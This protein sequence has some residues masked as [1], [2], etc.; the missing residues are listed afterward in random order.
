MTQ[1]V[2]DAGHGGTTDMGKSTAYGARGV[3]GTFEKDITLDIARRVA[4]ELGSTAS[5]TRGNDTNLPLAQRASMVGYGGVFVSIH[6]DAEQPGSGAPQAWVHTHADPNSQRLAHAI[7][8]SLDS[9]PGSYGGGGSTGCGDLALLQS[10]R[11]AACLVE[12][13]NIANPTT[14]RRLADPVERAAIGAAI[15][16][17]IR[18]YTGSGDGGYAE[19]LRIVTPN[20]DYRTTSLAD[21]VRI[22]ADYF[23]RYAQWTKG[24]D[25]ASLSHFPHSAICQLQLFNS[26]GSRAWGTGFF[27][28]PNKI[29]SCGHNFWDDDP[30]ETVRVLVQPGASPNMSI[31][32]EQEFTVRGRDLVHPNWR[33]GF[34]RNADLAVLNTPGLS[35]PGGHYFRLANQSLASDAKVVVCGYGKQ[36][37]SSFASQPQRMDGATISQADSE[38]V[39]YPI[40]TVGG[41][42]GSPLFHDDMVIGVHTGPRIV[43]ESPL[44]L[45]NHENRAVRIVPDNETWINRM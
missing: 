4:A 5:L 36:D 33:S 16:R 35:A 22:W 6:A 41:H 17:G 18:T 42:S 38:M 10:S 34:A 32:P 37:G 45:S 8:R 39:W 25:N 20:I 12:V 29:L 14:E 31:H 11:G 28:G 2:I 27:I 21:A 1:I 40:H 19:S 9:L 23:R 26:A 44:R 15:A 24:V 7:G 30:W 43:S 13:G 3:S